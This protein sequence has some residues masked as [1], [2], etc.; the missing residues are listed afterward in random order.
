MPGLKPVVCYRIVVVVVQ[1]LG[2][3]LNE[4]L[5]HSVQLM[6]DFSAQ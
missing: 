6:V 3:L 4:V 1:K 2:I 5:I